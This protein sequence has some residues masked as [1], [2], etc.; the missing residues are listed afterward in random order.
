MSD[1]LALMWNI[2]PGTEETVASLFENYASPE[3]IV[4]DDDGKEVGRLLSTQV[5]MKGNTIVRVIE[6]DG[7]LPLIGRHMSQ[8]KGI[9]ELEDRLEEYIEQP[10]DMN[11]PEG[12]RKFFMDTGMRCLVAR[13]Y[14]A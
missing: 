8:Q 4:Y 9:K 5:F 11:T 14:E 3:Y 6:Y 2:K 12:V 10:R 7:P 1:H 13:R